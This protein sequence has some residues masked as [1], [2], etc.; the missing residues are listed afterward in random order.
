MTKQT[1]KIFVYYCTAYAE[2]VVSHTHTHTHTLQ[3]S[4]SAKT[5]SSITF[6]WRR[7]KDRPA[8]IKHVLGQSLPLSGKLYVCC[9][10]TW[11]VLQY[12]PVDDWWAELPPP[13]VTDFTIATLKGQLLVVGGRESSTRKI[14]EKIFTFQE[15]SQQ[16]AKCYPDMTTA[17]MDP[18]ILGY[19][20]HLIVAGGLTSSQEW[21]AN[22]NILDSTSNRWTPVAPVPNADS[23]FTVMVRD[24]V[25]LVGRD[26]QT[27]LRAPVV[28]LMLGAKSGVWEEL[29][30]TPYSYSS[31]V[32]IGNTL[33]TIG[34]RDKSE[35][36]APTTSIQM[37]DPTTD[38]WTRM[39]DLPQP[40]EYI[41]CA[42]IQSE[43]F[44]FGN[45]FH[46]STHIAKLTL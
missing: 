25:Y 3:L 27:L 19:Q 43:M 1:V 22:V 39:G 8:T 29:T 9:A 4:E 34:G 37:Y 24:T 14:T 33:L 10:T 46:S 17:L 6:N 28:G 18:A 23:Y 26:T 42:V 13:S 16:W 30:D 21:T 31:P 38:Q 15:R 40:M 41:S 2:S 20:D 35:G 5:L 45:L 44:V 12:S 11:S 36:S 7:C 32:A